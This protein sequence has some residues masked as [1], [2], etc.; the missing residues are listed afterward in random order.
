MLT[1]KP[2]Y[3]Y[4]PGTPGVPAVPAVPAYRECHQVQDGHYETQAYVARVVIPAGTGLA[5]AVQI[6]LIPSGATILSAHDELDPAYPGVRFP[7]QIIVYFSVDAAVWVN[8]GPPRT[9]C[10]DY[11]EQPAVPAVPAVPARNEVEPVRAWDSGANS[12]DMVE[13]DCRALFTQPRAVGAVIGFTQSRGDVADISRFLAAFYFFQSAGGQPRYQL[14]E[15]A[16]SVSGAAP[17]APNE[18]E[19]ELRRVG[20]VTE[21]RIDGAVVR[22]TGAPEGPMSVGCALFATGDTAPGKG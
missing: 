12:I 16:A 8:D 3:T 22:R 17:Y 18:T 6:G 14:R 9:V 4:I 10:T 2:R 7:E 19:F 1:K 13:G 20:A 15:G 21:F 5:L 11:P